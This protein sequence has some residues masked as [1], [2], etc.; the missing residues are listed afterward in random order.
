MVGKGTYP[1][2]FLSFASIK[3]TEYKKMEYKITEVIVTLYAQNGYLLEGTL[4]N[5]NEKEYFKSI[6]PGIGCMSFIL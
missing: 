6:K 5:E 4:L 3:A 1:L 2:I